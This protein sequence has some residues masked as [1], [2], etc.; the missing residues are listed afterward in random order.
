MKRIAIALLGVFSFTGFHLQAQNEDDAVR[1]SQYGIFGT[2]SYVGR[3]GAIGALGGDFTAASYN[4]AGL[5]IYTKSE[6][7]FN[8]AVTD[9]YSRSTYQGQSSSDFRVGFSPFPMGFVFNVPA[10]SESS[11]MHSFQ[12]SF[13]ANTLKSNS[14][15]TDVLGINNQRSMMDVWVDDATINYS[16]PYTFDLAFATNTMFEDSLGVWSPF[17]VIEDPNG[18]ILQFKNQKEMGG[19]TEMVFSAS[20]NLNDFIYLGATIGVPFYDYQMYSTYTE[21]KSTGDFYTYNQNLNT[22]GVG[23]NL[24]L[25]AIVRPLDWLRVGAAFH[26]PTYYGLSDR[27]ETNL[28]HRNFYSS[29]P[30]SETDY[31]MTTPYKVLGNLGVILGNQSTP[32]AGSIGFDYEFSDYSTMHYYMNDSK[33]KSYINNLMSSDLQGSHTFKLGGTLNIQQFAVRAGYAFATSPYKD[34]FYN[35]GGQ[36]TIT[37]GLGY[38]A[39]FWYIDFAYANTYQSKSEY[40]YADN[41][42]KYTVNKYTNLFVATLGFRW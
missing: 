6:F 25:G 42:S 12:F 2:A 33:Y 8:S 26:T 1:M 11:Y 21:E 29:S 13:G 39:R 22:N 28:S 3:A 10:R 37:A 27:Y 40:L 34:E 31:G 14:N 38:R 5:G 7:L 15:R 35:I 30:Y 4:P 19:I 36:T 9:G 41:S 17:Q 32:V 16:N 20:T 18:E 24:K 23:I